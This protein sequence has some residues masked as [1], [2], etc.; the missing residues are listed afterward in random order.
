MYPASIMYLVVESIT[1]VKK[2]GSN[3]SLSLI[4]NTVKLRGPPKGNYHSLL[5]ETTLACKS[6]VV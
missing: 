3:A 2:R 5:L 1:R 4:G 6:V